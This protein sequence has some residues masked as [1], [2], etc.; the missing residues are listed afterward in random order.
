MQGAAAHRG[1]ST[2]TALTTSPSQRERYA[3]LLSAR[4]GQRSS[5]SVDMREPGSDSDPLSL[6]TCVPRSQT[7]HVQRRNLC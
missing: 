6:S 4:L 5:L 2:G 1:T 3:G 7:G